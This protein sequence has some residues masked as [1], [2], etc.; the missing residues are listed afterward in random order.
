MKNSILIA[1]MLVNIANG[2]QPLDHKAMR[3]QAYLDR[4]VSSALEH[5]YPIEQYVPGMPLYHEV[6]ESFNPPL[7]E[8]R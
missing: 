6:V 1:I 5:A 7:P 3:I 8:E 4:L 2:D